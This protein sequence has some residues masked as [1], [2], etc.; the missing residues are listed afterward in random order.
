MKST[1]NFLDMP[2]VIFYT[3][4]HESYCDGKKRLYPRGYD[5]AEFYVSANKGAEA[6]PMA[7]IAS[8]GELARIMLALKSAIVD[9]D[10]VGTV[11]YDEIDAGVSGK[12]ARKIGIKMLAL[13]KSAQLICV[14]HSAQ[15]A[16]L[17][18]TH[19]LIKKREISGS[20]ST[21]LF[22]LDYDGRVGEVSRILG[23]IDVTASQRQAAID[24]IN[25]KVSLLQ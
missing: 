3:S 4:Y 10:G 22:E 6:M 23:G 2:G 5:T 16:S 14:T 15:I 1:L 9:K 17:A 7:K 20:V 12:T 21:E 18:D 24:M 13:A 11:I 25:E 19:M 8:G